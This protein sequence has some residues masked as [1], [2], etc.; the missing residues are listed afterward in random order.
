MNV[1]NLSNALSNIK[2]A[3]EDLLS[4]FGRYAQHDADDMLHEWL[5]QLG[6]FSKGNRVQDDIFELNE[7]SMV[8]IFDNVDKASVVGAHRGVGCDRRG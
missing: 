4:Q 2:E 8:T 3:R 6:K 1:C 7:G 5:D